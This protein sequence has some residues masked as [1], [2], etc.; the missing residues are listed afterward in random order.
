[1]YSTGNLSLQQT[2]ERGVREKMK[3]LKYGVL[4]ACL[5]L[6]LTSFVPG[7]GNE[8][9]LTPEAPPAKVMTPE[10][11]EEETHGEAEK[12]RTYEKEMTER[13]QER[14]DL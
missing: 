12:E 7:C 13:S 6:L 8:E 9:E 2:S 5:A 4:V 3:Q 11:G 1:M 14:E 10:P